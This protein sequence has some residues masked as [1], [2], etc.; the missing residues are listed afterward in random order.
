M[1]PVVVALFVAQQVR[2][3]FVTIPLRFLVAAVCNGFVTKRSQTCRAQVWSRYAPVRRF[4][5]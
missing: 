5:T 4:A 2:S 1:W 3:G